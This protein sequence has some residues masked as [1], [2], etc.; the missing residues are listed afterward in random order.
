MKPTFIGIGAQKCATTWIYQ[1]L[2]EHP[3]VVVSD[4]KE[5]NYFSHNY[6]HGTQWYEDHFNYHHPWK[7]AGEISPSYFYEPMA[8]K[9]A[10][11]YS[12]NLKIIVS[13]RDP[14]ERA[15]SNHLHEVRVGHIW[16]ENLCFEQGI[17][18]NPMY[19]EQSRYATHLARWLNV[20]RRDQ[21]HVV[22]HEEMKSNPAQQA[23]RLYRFLEVDEDY[24]SAN[25]NKK[26]NRSFVP[27]SRFLGRLISRTGGIVRKA[28]MGKLIAA[29]KCAGL[30]DRLYEFN[31]K[32]VQLVIRPML[33]ET[34]W[35]LAQELK[36]ELRMLAKL[37][38][39]DELPWQ[40]W[41][42]IED[43]ERKVSKVTQI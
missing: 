38:G 36:N 22:I 8:V 7:A 29:A 9:R 40:S 17:R 27:R 11:D 43:Q 32:D 15:Y 18:N 1:V 39:K 6:D 3:E 37:L 2:K 34:K 19:L 4:P 10:F 30:V 26:F 35:E 16:G 20:F 23:R 24:R 33:D 31:R 14:I 21:I 28:G 13:L 25:I 42:I 41:K 5:L 12:P